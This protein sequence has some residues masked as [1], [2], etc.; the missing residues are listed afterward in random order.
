MKGFY[1]KESLKVLLDLAE[2]GSEFPDSP[3]KNHFGIAEITVAFPENN[4][5][6][7]IMEDGIEVQDIPTKEN[8]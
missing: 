2:W 1:T 8:K 7:T 3:H 4:M 5:L 6:V